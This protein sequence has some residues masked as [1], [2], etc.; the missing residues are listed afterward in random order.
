MLHV[1]AVIHCCGLVGGGLWSCEEN[2][3][4]LA[5]GGR[6]GVLHGRSFQEELGHIK[7]LRDGI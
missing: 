3:F 1:V 4:S 7:D 5:T 2:E 6:L